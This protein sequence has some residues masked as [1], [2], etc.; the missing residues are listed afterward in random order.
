[1]PKEDVPK[2]EPPKEDLPQEEPPT[3]EQEY[4]GKQSPRKEIFEERK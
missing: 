3:E 1:V 2:E 4:T